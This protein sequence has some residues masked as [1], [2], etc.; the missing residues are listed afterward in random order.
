MPEM[1]G[2]CW[3]VACGLSGLWKS[4]TRKVLNKVA[5][6]LPCLSPTEQACPGEI[7]EPTWIT[8]IYR[9]IKKRRILDLPPKICYGSLARPPDRAYF[10]YPTVPAALFHRLRVPRYPGV[11]GHM[12]VAQRS[13]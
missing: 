13:Y 6:P 11:A 5:P 8:K 3:A 10:K 4:W 2:R 12:Q 1:T 7:P 9:G